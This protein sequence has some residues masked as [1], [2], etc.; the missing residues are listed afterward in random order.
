MTREGMREQGQC[1]CGAVRFEAQVGAREIGAC[2]CSMCRRWS[3]GVFLAVECEEVEFADRSALGVYSSSEWGERCFCSS[4]GST[5]L[6]RS[7]DGSHHAVSVQ[8][9]ANP[10]DFRF[11]SQIFIDEKPDCYSFTEAT[12]NMTGA[13]F[14][15][16]VTSAESKA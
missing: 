12:K 14:I 16:M 4:C 7:K 1:L 6:W 10:S 8:A 9:F 15:A 3:G 2:H 13:D 5:L 11:V